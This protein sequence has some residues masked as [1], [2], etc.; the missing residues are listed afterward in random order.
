MSKIMLTADSISIM[1]DQLNTSDVVSLDFS[2]VEDINFGAM[3]ALLRA[4]KDGYKFCI[5]NANPI[6][7]LRLENGGLTKYISA[8]NAPIKIDMS[9]FVQSGDGYCGVSYFSDD[10]D[11]MLKLYN[12]FIADNVIEQEKRIATRAFQLGISTPLAGAIVTTGTQK[13][14]L[15]E[16][17]KG[18]RSFSRAIADEPE[19]LEFYAR[20]FARMCKEL[21][22]TECDTVVFP[23]AVRNFE[24]ELEHNK[25][26][27]EDQTKKILDFL[28]SVPVRTTCLHGDMHIGNVITTG[29]EDLWIAMSEFSYGNPMFDMSMFYIACTQ[30]S[31]E[32]TMEYYHVNNE[33]MLKFWKVFACEYYGI[34]ESELEA[35]NESLKPYAALRMVYFTT[36]GS[37]QP[38]NLAFIREFLNS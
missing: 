10:E 31:E 24:R 17:I 34:K 28:H 21:H 23:S 38:R 26:F 8:C 22:S 25:A 16:R 27:T 37:I 33:M 6:V 3:R 12:S 4:F 5:I 30:D 15:Y 9:H 35:V 32:F 18:K 11:S 13:G 20:R 29:K 2:E 14:I 36:L 7:L 19:K 1:T